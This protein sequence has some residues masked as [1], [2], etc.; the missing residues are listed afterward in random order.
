MSWKADGTRYL[1]FIDNGKVFMIGRDNCVFEVPYMY[2]PNA[3]NKG[4][5]E[6]TLLDGELVRDTCWV[7]GPKPKEQPVQI[8]QWN[9]YACVESGGSVALCSVCAC[10]SRV[11]R[12]AAKME[13][14]G[15]EHD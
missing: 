7:K 2:F 9:Y 8:G 1:M 6:T 10:A 15:K 11:V 14:P 4:N 3:A 13:A 5:V 12:F